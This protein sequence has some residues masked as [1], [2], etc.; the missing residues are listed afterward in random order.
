[1]LLYYLV[2]N[3]SALTQDRDK[4]LFPRWLQV[5]GAAACLLLV[6]TL[7]WPSVVGG[8]VVFVVGFGYRLVRLRW[9][10]SR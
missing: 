5:L 7:P 1:V 10:V 9:A 4:R 8:V 2:A 3:L 6:V